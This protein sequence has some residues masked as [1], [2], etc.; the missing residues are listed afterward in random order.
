M[1]HRHSCHSIYWHFVGVDVICERMSM[2]AKWLSMCWCIQHKQINPPYTVKS[3]TQKKL[4]VDLIGILWIGQV[5][6]TELTAIEKKIPSLVK[7]YECMESRVQSFSYGMNVWR[8]GF[9]FSSIR[10]AW[11][12][13]RVQTLLQFIASRFSCW[14][15]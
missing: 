12:H 10:F 5:E 3:R 14:K 15:N 11:S 13:E 2:C 9:A 1:S 7:G 4:L 8:W 6:I